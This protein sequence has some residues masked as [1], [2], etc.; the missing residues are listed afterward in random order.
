MNALKEKLNHLFSEERILLQ[1]RGQVLLYL[2]RWTL[3][4]V[5]VGTL[6]GA[7][8]AGF[9]HALSY[10]TEWRNTYDFLLYLLPVA[11]L[12]IAL[13]YRYAP[14]S[15]KGTNLVIASIRQEGPI[16]PTMAPLIFVSTLL[17]H[18]CGGSAGREGAALQ[19]GGSIAQTVGRGLRLKERDLNIITMCGMSACFAALFS[20]PLAASVFCIEV[21]TVGIMHYSALVPCVLSAITATYVGSLLG[22]HPES[23]HVE[24]MV[25]TLDLMTVLQVVALGAL[26]ALVSILFCRTMHTASHLANKI[27]NPYLRILAGSA[28]IIGITLLLGTRD[29]NGA[30]MPMIELAVEGHAE[31]LA[32]LI[33]IVLT[34]ITLGFGFKGGEIVPSFFVGATFGCVVGP[35]L[36]LDAGFAAALGLAAVFCGVTNCPI[37]SLLLACELFGFAGAP[38]FFLVIAVCYPLS[39]Y[40]GLYSTQRIAYSKTHTHFVN[41]KTN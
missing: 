19:L 32:F 4:A 27:E 26:C 38:Y 36:G 23:M 24:N 40:S 13:M 30:G 16:P 35:L 5:S 12:L 25:S 8:G 9:F 6:I 15:Q 17:T 18:L 7:I 33:K 37:A 14:Q 41:L 28:L 20:T 39:G 1:K 31:P 10:V 3:I 2:I 34:A 11:G 21:V 29:Y 22:T